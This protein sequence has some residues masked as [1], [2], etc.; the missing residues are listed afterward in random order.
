MERAATIS[1]APEEE[2]EAGADEG[3]AGMELMGDSI[4][5]AGAS[6]KQGKATLRAMVR[7]LCSLSALSL[8]RKNCQTP[9]TDRSVASYELRSNQSCTRDLKTAA[10]ICS[11]R[12][13][14]GM[15]MA[16]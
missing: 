9:H 6:S 12:I 16:M 5:V 10:F 15:S 2:A 14:I 1:R 4:M 8:S 13:V 3:W 11:I 7:V